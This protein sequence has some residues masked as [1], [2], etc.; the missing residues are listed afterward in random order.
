[1]EICRRRNIRQDVVCNAAASDECRGIHTGHTEQPTYDYDDEDDYEA[2][3]KVPTCL[4][5]FGS[6]PPISKDV[7]M[8]AYR[9]KAKTA[10]PDSGGTHHAFLEV[11][12][13][14]KEALQLVRT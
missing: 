10:H 8:R 5:F 13:H 2:P 7:L 12:K 11:S 1:M 14:F 4:A 3:P 6:T 9:Q